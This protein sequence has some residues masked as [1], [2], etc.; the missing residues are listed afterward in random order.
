MHHT[1]KMLALALTVLCFGSHQSNA[2]ERTIES[3][4]ECW[5]T[6]PPPLQVAAKIEITA[7]LAAGR[8]ADISVDRYE[9][10][11]EA[12]YATAQ[13]AVR[14]LELCGPYGDQTG[15]FAMTFDTEAE[16]TGSTT[17]S[18]PLPGQQ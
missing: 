4:R 15:T 9:P 8:V 12:G 3:A 14:A 6:L 10:D 2:E 13:S 16:K 17:V 5:N 18:I 1:H 7:T 11:S